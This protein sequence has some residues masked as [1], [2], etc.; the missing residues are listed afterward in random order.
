MTS[1]LKINIE[2]MSC[3]HCISSVEKTVREIKGVRHVRVSLDEKAAFIEGENLD[4]DQIIEQI[5]DIG[6]EASI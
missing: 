3:N 5:N 6:F 1:Q 4:I 2:G